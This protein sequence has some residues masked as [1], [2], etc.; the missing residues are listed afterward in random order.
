MAYDLDRDHQRREPPYRPG[1]VGCVLDDAVRPHT[2]GIVV[3][4][5]GDGAS[6]RYRRIHGGRFES[7]DNSDQIREENENKNGG[8]VGEIF[9]SAVPQLIFG[10]AVNEFI[11][12]L[13]AMLELSG[14]VIGKLPP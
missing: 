3:E 4:K 7:G 10:L 14:T 11:D 13:E 12:Q 1:K 2:H 5:G 8:E 6:G 9:G